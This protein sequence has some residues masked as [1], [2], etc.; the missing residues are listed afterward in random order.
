MFEYTVDLVSTGR[1]EYD[2]S[3][4]NKI[5]TDFVNNPYPENVAN[6]LVDEALEGNLSEVVNE[7][8]GAEE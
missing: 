5:V 1:D 4:T 2:D 6:D 7:I 8:T 3:G